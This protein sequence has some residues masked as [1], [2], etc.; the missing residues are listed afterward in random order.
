MVVN[1]SNCEIGRN[2]M[3]HAAFF[4]YQLLDEGG[5]SCGQTSY[6]LF[7]EFSIWELTDLEVN[8]SNGVSLGIDQVFIRE[9]AFIYVLCMLENAYSELEPHEWPTENDKEYLV[10][11]NKGQDLIPEISL[12]LKAIEASDSGL[13]NQ[14]SDVIFKKYVKGRFARLSR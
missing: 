1:E 4:Y 9:A 6:W 7:E 10:L 14:A 8:E 13:F 3:M 5:F 12:V 11:R 2:A